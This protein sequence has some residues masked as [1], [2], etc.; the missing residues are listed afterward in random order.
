MGV[1]RMTVWSLAALLLAVPACRSESYSSPTTSMTPPSPDPPRSND[2]DARR[3]R[4]APGAPTRSPSGAFV[5]K[6]VE[7]EQQRDGK[8][9]R[10]VS[11]Q[12]LSP[13]GQV[14]FEP[15]QP[16]AGWFTVVVGW[17][18]Q[19]RVWLRSGDIGVRVWSHGDAGWNEH[20]WQKDGPVT[21]SP[22]RVVWDAETGSDVPVI[23]GP[24]PEVIQ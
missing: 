13:D 5:L 10:Y 22:S 24:L 6:L 21:P 16:F 14:R 9:W 17:D 8:A 12:I 19:D 11:F 7:S 20:V 2:G 4:A 15:R 18:A 1:A 3:F 23:G